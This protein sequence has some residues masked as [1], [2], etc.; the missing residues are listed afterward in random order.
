M[1]VLALHNWGCVSEEEAGQ[2]DPEVRGGP[3]TEW[4][5]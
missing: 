3:E 5:W 4:K 2:G 1:G